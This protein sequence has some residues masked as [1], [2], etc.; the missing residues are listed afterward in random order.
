[1]ATYQEQRERDYQNKLV[2]RFVDELDYKYLGNWQYAKGETVNSL[3]KQNSPILDDEIRN[4]LKEQKK[5]DGK[6]PRYTE[7]QIEDALFQIKNKARLGNAK[8]NSLMQCNTDLYDVLMSGGKSQ[9]DPESNHEDVMFFDF[10]DYSNNNFAIAEE[11]SYIDPLLGKNKCPDIVVY[12]NGI[13]LAVIELKRSLVNYEEGI[14]QHL[15]NERDF[16][17]SFFTTTQFTIASNDGVVFRYGTVGTPLKFWCKW[18]RDTTKL[19]DVLTEQESYS[20]FFNK[21][22]FMFFFRYGVLN[23]GGI[24]KVL[25]PHQIYAIKAAAARMPKKESGVIWHSQGPGRALRWLPWHLIYA[26]TL[27]T[28]VLLS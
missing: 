10:E 3:G 25:R 8:M 23:D 4:F 2:K 26:A 19:G 12:V 1:M 15:S 27:R 9:P 6:T 7:R 24:K 18:K 16:I 17:P 11:V 28:L 14:K 13:A 5:E 20:M 22:N 21:E